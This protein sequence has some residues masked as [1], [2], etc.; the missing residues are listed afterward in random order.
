MQ[1]LPCKLPIERLHRIRDRDRTCLIKLSR[2]AR[3]HGVMRG[4]Y[5]GVPA[6]PYMHAGS[7]R[8]QRGGNAY[9]HEQIWNSPFFCSKTLRAASAN[10]AQ[11][12]QSSSDTWAHSLVCTSVDWAVWSEIAAL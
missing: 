5:T 10:I 3:N 1:S 8:R 4:L 2:S 11:I 7:F 12:S 6:L 9:M